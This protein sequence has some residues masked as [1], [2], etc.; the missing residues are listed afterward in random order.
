MKTVVGSERRTQAPRLHSLRNM[1]AR[2]HALN[3]LLTSITFRI[4]LWRLRKV[5][6]VSQS[7][8]DVRL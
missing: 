3:P 4:V 7:E 5:M 8:T 1:R 2:I 6:R